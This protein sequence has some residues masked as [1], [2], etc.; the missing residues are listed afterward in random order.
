MAAVLSDS[1]NKLKTSSSADIE[2]NEELNEELIGENGEQS[3]IKK[4]KNR[5]KKKK[6]KP[7]DDSLD[8]AMDDLSVDNQKTNGK[9]NNCEDIET[10]DG[11]EPQDPQ[12]ES[13]KKKKKKKTK[14]VANESSTPVSS[15]S[16][17][18]QQTTPPSVPI[19]E[20]FPDGNFPIGQQMEYPIPHDR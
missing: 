20:L 19:A 10:N 6:T 12:K 4:K 9:A 16:V 8:K 14:S 2:D 17:G 1:N 18:K 7:T 5:K 15:G 11:N 3:D 13:L